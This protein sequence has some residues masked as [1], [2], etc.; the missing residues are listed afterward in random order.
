[1]QELYHEIQQLAIKAYKAIDGEGYARVD[2]FLDR[3]TGKLYLNE[4]NTIP[5]FTRFSMFPLL[6]REAGIEYDKLLERI[7]ELG[8]ERY[9]AKNNG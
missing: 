3:D 7:I 4:I 1:M 9:H 8:Y 6:C 5:G 2:F